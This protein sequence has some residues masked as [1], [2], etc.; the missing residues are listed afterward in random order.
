MY[1]QG[2]IVIIKFPFTDGSEFKRRPALI[3]L[4]E[5][6]NKTGDYMLVQITSKFI[7]D[8]LS[9]KINKSDCFVELPLQ[10]YI[11]AHKIFTVNNS[12]IISKLTNI[13]SEFKNTVVEKITQLIK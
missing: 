13:S 5:L 10:S 12:L 7:D 11:R 4:N 2:E 6:A 1:N 3:I 8:N 9:I